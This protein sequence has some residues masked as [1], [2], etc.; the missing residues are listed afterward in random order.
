MKT[1]NSRSEEL[2]QTIRTSV[3]ANARPLLLT[4]GAVVTMN[5]VIGDWKIA[6]V[7]LF[8]DTIVGVGPG[9]MKAAEDDKSIVINCEGMLILPASLDFTSTLKSG[10]LT[11]GNRANLAVLKIDNLE[12]NAFNKNVLS[13][14]IDLIITNGKIQAWNGTRL[15]ESD[16]DQIPAGTLQNSPESSKYQGMWVDENDFVRQELLPNGRYDEARGDRKSAFQGKYWITGN[17]IDYLD[18]LGFWAFGEFNDGRLDH[19]GYRFSMRG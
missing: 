15:E 19:A 3:G 7:L 17:R 16:L 10:S 1:Q 18:D 11:P 8:Q 6:D 4:G 5:P 9:L 13:S 14:N 2:L 12:D